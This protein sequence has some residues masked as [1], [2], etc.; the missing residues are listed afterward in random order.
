MQLSLRIGDQSSQDVAWFCS[1][2]AEELDPA[3]PGR[4]DPSSEANKGVNTWTLLPTHGVGRRVISIL[5]TSCCLLMLSVV[6][7]CVT[8]RTCMPRAPVHAHSHGFTYEMLQI[9]KRAPDFTGVRLVVQAST[10]DVNVLQL[11]FVVMGGFWGFILF[12]YISIS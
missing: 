8:G 12:H 3:A 9:T 10:R 4:P 7:L 11:Q 6:S 5:K 2:A 1:L